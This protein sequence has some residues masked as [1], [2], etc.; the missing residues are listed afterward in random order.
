MFEVAHCSSRG[1]SFAVFWALKYPEIFKY[2][3]T[4]HFIPFS[5]FPTEIG[6][7][8]QPPWQRVSLALNTPKAVLATLRSSYT[9]LPRTHRSMWGGR[10]VVNRKGKEVLWLQLWHFLSDFYDFCTSGNSNKYSTVT[11]LM[12]QWRRKCVTSHR[13]VMKFYF[14][15]LLPRIK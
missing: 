12:A 6:Q 3:V 7:H 13:I 9:A 1:R 10:F 2:N 14:I 5:F 11:Y 4:F 15:Q 8:L